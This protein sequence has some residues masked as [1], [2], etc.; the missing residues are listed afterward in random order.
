[1]VESL[2]ELLSSPLAKCEWK[3]RPRKKVVTLDK[4]VI[5]RIGWHSKD[6]ATSADNIKC[7]RDREHLRKL[8]QERGDEN[9]NNLP[10]VY[11]EIRKESEISTLRSKGS[12]DEDNPKGLM[13]GSPRYETQ[14][15]TA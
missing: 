13:F 11:S 10:G 7:S 5:K 15:N 9:A 8:S 4:D 2:E 14:C 12:S 1:M 6:L 3:A